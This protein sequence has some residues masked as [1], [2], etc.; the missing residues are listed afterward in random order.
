MELPDWL[1]LAPY[2]YEPM[3]HSGTHDTDKTSL[4][5]HPLLRWLSV[6]IERSRDVYV[7]LT[8]QAFQGAVL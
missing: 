2:V 1:G 8:P 7:P 3:C 6:T 4:R 5:N